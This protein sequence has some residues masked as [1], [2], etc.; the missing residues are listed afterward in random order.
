[1]NPAEVRPVASRGHESV[2]APPCCRRK[3][4][5]GSDRGMGTKVMVKP[6]SDA[7]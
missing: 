5:A 4:Y 7:A 2:L 1:M 3:H 6:R